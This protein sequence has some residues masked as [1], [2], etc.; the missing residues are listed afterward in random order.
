MRD[1]FYPFYLK[2]LLMESYIASIIVG[3]NTSKEQWWNDTDRENP[4]YW[5]KNQYDFVHH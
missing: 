3:L 2:P 1:L 4:K 5:D